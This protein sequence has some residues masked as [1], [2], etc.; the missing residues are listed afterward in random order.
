MRRLLRHAVLV[1][2]LGAAAVFAQFAGAKPAPPNVTGTA[3]GTVDNA[4]CSSYGAHG[5]INW[6]G[7]KVDKVVVELGSN[8]GASVGTVY[9]G[10]TPTTL[11]PAK[12]K[13]SLSYSFSGLSIP[14]A[15][16]DLAVVAKFFLGTTEYSQVA[17]ID[18]GNC[19]GL[20]DLV[21]T[22]IVPNGTSFDVTVKN[23]GT[24]A[25]SLDQTVTIQAYYS[26]SSDT[27]TFPPLGGSPP[28]A[29][30]DPACGT[31]FAPTYNT[32]LQ[33]GSSTTI[34][35][36]CS[37]PSDSN[38]IYLV[39]EVDATNVIAESDETNNVFSIALT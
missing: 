13:G 27:T 29:G 36:S 10:P 24:A 1:L 15:S 9:G 17:F 35:M 39:A 34:P 19:T 25:A 21:I 26:S 11:S 14:S 38:D 22:S 3:T 32:V 33:P 8:S 28:T 30:G 18:L 23:Q 12:N 2:A 16:T 31:S 5:V 6:S 20:P 37:S 7:A 4:N